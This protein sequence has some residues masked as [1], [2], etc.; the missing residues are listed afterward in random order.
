MFLR[1]VFPDLFAA[2]QY[3][4]GGVIYNFI[5][6]G[7]GHQC[8]EFN[9]VVTGKFAEYFSADGNLIF[10]NPTL[11]PIQV[12]G[13]LMGLV[14]GS[15]IDKSDGMS[16]AY[17]HA[18][19]NFA[20]M[21]L[22]SVIGHSIGHPKSA[23]WQFGVDVDVAF[24]G[25]SCICLLLAALSSQGIIKIAPSLVQFVAPVCIIV[26]LFNTHFFMLP[27]VSELMYLGNL[28][29]AVIVL[30]WHYLNMYGSHPSF[31]SFMLP[32]IF[33]ILI[34]VGGIVFEDTLCRLST[35]AFSSICAVFLACCAGFMSVYLF[36]F[37]LEAKRILKQ[38]KND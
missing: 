28:N 17:S 4:A 7:E 19:W 24:T 6:A 32:G 11:L 20:G 30:F 10:R 12:V 1:D 34:L 2:V 22:F 31:W 21:N 18:F 29:V 37:K 14:I 23:T 8:Y 35:G 15:A 16:A 25:A 27:F 3:K 36:A 13:M 26:V 33:G 5:R 38:R 9:V